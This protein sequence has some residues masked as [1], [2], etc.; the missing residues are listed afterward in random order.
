MTRA[1]VTPHLNEALIALRKAVVASGELRS[2]DHLR[3]MFPDIPALVPD[4][5]GKRIWQLIESL[6]ALAKEGA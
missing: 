5:R 4:S 6:E 1:K 3:R 2:G